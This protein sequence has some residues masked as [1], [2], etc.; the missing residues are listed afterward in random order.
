MKRAHTVL[1]HKAQELVIDVDMRK[2][3]F[4]ID[5][6]HVT[7]RIT[8]QKTTFFFQWRSKHQNT[9]NFPILTSEGQSMPS[10]SIYNSMTA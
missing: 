6:E 3:R 8:C 2:A 10:S 7:Q 4:C 1:K 5:Q 9:F